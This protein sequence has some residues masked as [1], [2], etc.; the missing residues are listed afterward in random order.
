MEM[1]S[2]LNERQGGIENHVVMFAFPKLYR[3]SQRIYAHRCSVKTPV[4]L[5][6]LVIFDIPKRYVSHLVVIVKK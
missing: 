1:L 3:I 2:S 5:G 4:A 6:T